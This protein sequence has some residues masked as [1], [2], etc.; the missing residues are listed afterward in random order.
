MVKRK[1]FYSLQHIMLWVKIQ[2]L[3]VKYVASNESEMN[4]GHTTLWP[5]HVDISQRR[6][7]QNSFLDAAVCLH[8]CN[9]WT[10][11]RH[12]VTHNSSLNGLF[13][14]SKHNQHFFIT[15]LLVEPN[16]FAYRVFH[17]KN[18]KS[19][20]LKLRNRSYLMLCW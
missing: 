12:F 18:Y 7:S 3:S 10:M 13:K 16:L 1:V 11:H 2:V 15:L 9:L 5:G 19:K 6:I 14:D 8:M 4:C 17:L 20:S